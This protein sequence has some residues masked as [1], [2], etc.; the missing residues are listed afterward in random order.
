MEIVLATRNKGKIR[1]LQE[2]LAG[3]PVKVRSIDEFKDVPEVEET[4]ETFADNAL[5][6]AR[7]ACSATGLPA[8]ADDSGLCV[9]ALDGAPGVRS[10]RFSGENATDES[11][12]AKLLQELAGL[13]KAGRTARFVCVL[14]L[15]RPGGSH[16]FFGGECPG[17]ILENPR[18]DAGFGYDPLFLDETLGKTFGELT[19]EEKLSRSHRG[20]ALRSF[21]KHLEQQTAAQ[22]G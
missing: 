13:K 8:L 22:R 6:K 12:N 18:G 9:D 1:E 4:G 5:L 2:F 10:A 19:G 7:A 14:C 17:V 3:L 11:N 21:R 20:M 15:A 16:E